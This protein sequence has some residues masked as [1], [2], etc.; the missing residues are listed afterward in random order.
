MKLS[1]G[2]KT[3]P[4]RTDYRG[5]VDVWREADRIPEIEHAW[6]WDHFVPLVG[7]ATDAVHEGWT[8]LSALAAQ[9]TRLRLGVMVT[10]NAARPPA[11]LGKMAATVDHIS[12]GRLLLGL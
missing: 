6:V 9:T 5:I 8:L 12:A 10:S 3:S 2:I 4:M 7:P 11:V 1:F